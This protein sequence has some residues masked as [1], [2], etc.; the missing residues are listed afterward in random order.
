MEKIAIIDLG[1][2]SARLVLVNILE[3]GYFA[4][5]DELKETVRL[6]QDMQD[7]GFLRPTRI[8]Q[9]IKTL[10]MF[11]R[12]CDANRVD[13]IYAYATAAVRR[14]K[15]QRGFLD[16]VQAQC[17]FRLEVLDD[18][19]EAQLVY[20]GV[21]NSMDIPRGL[22]MDMG[23]GSTQFVYYNRKNLL[24]H[25]TLPYGAVT[26]TDMYKDEGLKPAERAEKIKQ[27]FISELDKI[28]FLKEMDPDTRLIGVGG[29]FRNLGKISRMLRKYPLDMTHNYVVNKNEFNSIYN[30]IK[31]LDLDKTMKI[32]GLSSVRAD[33]FPSA[34]SAMS[35]VM[36]TLNLEEVVVSGS[37]LR[38]G[39]M[40]KYAV[41][42]TNEKPIT[43]V[44]GHSI[45]TILNF[46]QENVKHAEQVYN[47]STQLFKQLRVLHKLPR[48]YVKVLRTAAM[49]HD[50]GNRIKYYDHHKHSS[51]IILNSNLYGISHKDLVMSALVASMHRK[52][53]LDANIFMKYRDMLTEEDIDAV[54]KLG[55]IV[56]IA[57][58]LDRSMSSVITNIAC[59][60]LGDSVIMKTE[61]NGGDCSLEVKDALTASP[62]FKKYYK[63]NLQIL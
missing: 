38:E 6:A 44:L 25:Y 28:E 42:S 13:R 46:F 23:G 35:A 39:T 40:F 48:A 56:R 43:D 36:D 14:A 30:N 55:V 12:L 24:G 58:S 20:Q 37:G 54:M 9:T 45:Y 49:L 52:G 18:D 17:G 29:S 62:E 47:L 2:N 32:K 60:V 31:T 8:A 15:N 1:S 10:Q 26:L 11:R 16:E 57:E 63:K 21:I 50:T 3:G 19:T 61:T 5:F 22:I 51:Y 7:D 59:D 34:L 4:V 33:I 41:P 53:E 27:F